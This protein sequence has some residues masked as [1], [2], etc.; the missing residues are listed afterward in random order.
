MFHCLSGKLAVV[1]RLTRV[2]FS[3]AVRSVTVRLQHGLEN[4]VR[5]SECG[6]LAL[7]ST[8]MQ[9]GHPPDTIRFNEVG[10]LNMALREHLRAARRKGAAGR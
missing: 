2:Y 5:L 9:T 10:Y 7:V 1:F 3:G 6:N 8:I 4:T